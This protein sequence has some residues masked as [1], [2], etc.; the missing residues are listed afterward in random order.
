MQGSLLE[1]KQLVC[2]PSHADLLPASKAT[3]GIGAYELEFGC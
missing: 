3:K 2:M 1:D